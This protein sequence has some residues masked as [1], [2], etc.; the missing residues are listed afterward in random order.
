MKCVLKLTETEAQTLEEMARHHPY[1]DFRPRAIGLL[2]LADGR[3]VPDIALFLRVSQQTVYQ[4]FHDWN[5]AGVMGILGGHAGGRP[6]VMS[7]AMIDTAV[8]AACA[9]QMRLAEI[10]QCIR[11]AHPNAPE[12]SLDALSR[13]LKS[14]RIS[15]QRTRLSLKEK[16]PEAFDHAKK[17]LSRFQQAANQGIARLIFVDESGFASTPNVQRAW[18]P[19]R[20]PHTTIAVGHSKRVSVIG[21]LDAVSNHLDFDTVQ[22]TVTR[23]R[24]V[25][26]LDRISQESDGRP[27]FV[28]LDNAAIH[29]HID[30]D[31]LHGWLVEHKMILWYLPAYSP[32]LNRIEIVWKQAKYCW[33]RFTTWAANTLETKVRAL[34]E[35]YGNK[36]QINFA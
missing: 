32:E 27:M 22:T 2:A 24:V 11:D 6:L 29:H 15:Y 16:R 36:F 25:A 13:A 19:H 35:G 20:Q 12:F 9:R 33:R 17:V 3:H 28:V 34:F 4:W 8:A 30:P 10:A 18:A 14:R 23:E 21:A 26:F 7:D 31:I 5:R 1:A